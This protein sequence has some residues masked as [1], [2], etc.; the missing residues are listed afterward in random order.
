MSNG[1]KIC[2]CAQILHFS[3]LLGLSSLK[4]GLSSFNNAHQTRHLWARRGLP[5]RCDDGA[6]LLL[7]VSRQRSSS[8][9]TQLCFNIIPHHVYA[10]TGI[11]QT[12]HY[13]M[14]V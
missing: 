3:I 10:T 9:W 13:V 1:N 11:T 4:N 5:H 6:G 12:L 7:A 2:T 8:S 14:S